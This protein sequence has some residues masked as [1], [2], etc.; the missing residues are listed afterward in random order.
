[1]YSNISQN[2]A[3]ESPVFHLDHCLNLSL[4][5]LRS[6]QCMIDSCEDDEQNILDNRIIIIIR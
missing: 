4:D 5:L 3:L 2:L 6:G 1:M